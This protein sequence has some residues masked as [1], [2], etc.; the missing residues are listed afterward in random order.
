VFAFAWG[1]LGGGR[2]LGTN[3]Q[4]H[5][6]RFCEPIERPASY[7]DQRSER[8]KYDLGD[9]K[10]ITQVRSP[11]GF[12]RAYACNA[13]L[14]VGRRRHRLPERSGVLLS[15]IQFHNM[16]ASAS[17][18]STSSSSASQLVGAPNRPAGA[19]RINPVR[20]QLIVTASHLSERMGGV[21]ADGERSRASERF[22]SAGPRP[23]GQT[24]GFDRWD[25]LAAAERT[26]LAVCRCLCWH[27]TPNWLVSSGICTK[28]YIRYTSACIANILLRPPL[29]LTV[30]AALWEKTMMIIIVMRYFSS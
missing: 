20:R 26:A 30:L 5:L 11:T 22:R 23:C 19:K 25:T 2:P 16:S 17:V 10:S 12:R 28:Q 1:Q 6:R 14:T 24:R 18:S 7:F 27:E 21:A 9:G 4:D 13:R 8:W 15:L 3:I 29:G